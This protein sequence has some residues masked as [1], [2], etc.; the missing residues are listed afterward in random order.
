MKKFVKDLQ[1]NRQ[2]GRVRDGMLIR[3]VL[4][5]L[6]ENASVEEVEPAGEVVAT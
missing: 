3:K 5:F 1:K 4:D 6:K 2:I